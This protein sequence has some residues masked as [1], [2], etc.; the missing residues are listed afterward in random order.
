MNRS[1]GY[2][3]IP[4][5]MKFQNRQALQLETKALRVTVLTEGGHIAEILHKKA[6]INP[7]WIPPWSSIEPSQY[8]ARLHPQYGLN[9]ESKL[10]SGIMGHSLC[11]DIFGPPSNEEL[12]H[13]ISVHG[14]ASVA[15]F[16]G[17]VQDGQLC[18]SA[19]L[20]HSML[21]I[22]RVIGIDDDELHV[23][24]RESVDNLSAVDRPIA[25]TQHVSLGPPFLEAGATQLTIR[26]ERSRVFESE[27]FDSGGLVRGA[28]FDWPYAPKPGGDVA[29]LRV[30]AGDAR[31]SSFTAHL[32]NRSSNQASFTAYSPVAHVFFGYQ[33][34]RRD[35]PWL[36]IWEENK[37][38]QNQPWNGE[39]VACG[40][41]F[42]VSPF[43]EGREKM[44]Q[45]EKLFGASAFRRLR[46]SERVSVEYS[47]FVGQG[48]GFPGQA[49][50][51][52]RQ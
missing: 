32:L 13:G 45:R 17:D 25:W 23:R 39:T 27:G 21:R 43:P 9:V 34:D 36:G 46:G 19:V 7:L 6:G 29:D 33:W 20:P 51:L 30:F 5:T 22:T 3:W 42:G 18:L 4:K 47:A 2:G 48:Q 11:L 52:V 49:S 10:L 1:S 15:P 38:R 14:E 16:V 44:V 35:F 37:S 26:P 24:I 8:D 40:L 12:S 31:T 28:D 41:E 50:G